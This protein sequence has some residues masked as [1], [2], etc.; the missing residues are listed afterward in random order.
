MPTSALHV[1]RTGRCVDWL[2]SRWVALSKR[3]ERSMNSRW[4]RQGKSTIERSLIYLAKRPLPSSTAAVCPNKIFLACS[5]MGAD[6]RSSLP[7]ATP[8]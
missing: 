6:E 3:Q 1:A 2:I 4:G 8:R 7:A 5:S